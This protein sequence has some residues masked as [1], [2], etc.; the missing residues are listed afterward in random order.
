M[1]LI[2]SCDC[3]HIKNDQVMV[4]VMKKDSHLLGDMINDPWVL[5]T[6]DTTI[7]QE[8]RYDREENIEDI[9]RVNAAYNI[10]KDI[11]LTTPF[12][13]MNGM[14]PQ[15][16]TRYDNNTI[17]VN[18]DIDT[19]SKIIGPLGNFVESIVSELYNN[20]NNYAGK[21][22]ITPFLKRYSKIV[23]TENEQS[24]KELYDD[25]SCMN[26][27]KLF[28]KN[29]YHKDING[30]V[31]ASNVLNNSYNPFYIYELL[32]TNPA[33]EYWSYQTPRFILV[34]EEMI[35]NYETRFF[36]VNG[37]IVSASGRVIDFVPT[38]ES[39]KNPF[40]YAQQTV[41]HQSHSN[42]N[43]E[44]IT[45]SHYDHMVEYVKDIIT[46][47]ENNE[48][49]F[50]TCVIDIAWSPEKQSPV[51]VEI[52]NISNSGLYGCSAHAIYNELY[53]NNCYQG[54]TLKDCRNEIKN[55]VS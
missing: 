9:H 28:I 4:P 17:I 35:M 46:T 29:P 24:L 14:T 32:E 1:T 25:I 6:N 15:Y 13:T 48:N 49:K 50:P 21:T 45:N 44:I 19:E 7:L 42:D 43:Q 11:Y 34:Q 52:N 22:Y 23:D 12:D 5:V 54:L 41:K 36:I 51:L 55:L 20:V 2:I 38:Q 40:H 3:Y 26:N 33:F 8:S 31:D 27:K 47:I 37:V 16:C 18:S 53:D 39:V 10:E 30:I